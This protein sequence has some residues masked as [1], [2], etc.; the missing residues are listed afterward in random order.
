MNATSIESPDRLMAHR[1]RLL[2]ALET[3]YK[4][5][6]AGPELSMHRHRTAGIAAKHLQ[7]RAVGNDSAGVRDT[8][9][10]A[11]LVFVRLGMGTQIGFKLLHGKSES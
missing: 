9:I 8:A 6:H 11:E 4:Q 7:V 5:I 2:P 3:A 1:V 10:A